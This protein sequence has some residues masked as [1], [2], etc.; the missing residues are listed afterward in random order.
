MKDNKILFVLITVLLFF[1]IGNAQ[2]NLDEKSDFIRGSV[3]TSLNK[4]VIEYKFRSFEDLNQGIVDIV[5]DFDCASN[6]N[7]KQGSELVI[8]I[9]LEIAIGITSILLTEII[10]SKCS[11]KIEALVLK[12]LKAISVA[13]AI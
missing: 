9:K 2:E 3:I 1:F 12:R 10:K 11:D 7:L 5:K 4:E 6:E 13:A 8:E